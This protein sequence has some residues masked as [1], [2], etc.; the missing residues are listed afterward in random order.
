MVQLSFQIKGRIH[1]KFVENDKGN[2]LFIIFQ[3]MEFK[4]GNIFTIMMEIYI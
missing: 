1:N 4:L 3:Y 2:T